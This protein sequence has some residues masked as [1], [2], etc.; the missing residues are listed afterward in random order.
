MSQEEGRSNPMIKLSLKAPLPPGEGLGRG[1]MKTAFNRS[2]TSPVTL[3]LRRLYTW[4][5]NG[6]ILYYKNQGFKP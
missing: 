4:Q 6:L 3:N 1:R 2:Q 5:T